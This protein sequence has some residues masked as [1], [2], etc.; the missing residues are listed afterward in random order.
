MLRNVDAI[1]ARAVQ[2]PRGHAFLQL[3]YTVLLAAYMGVFVYTGSTEGGASAFG[4]TTMAL[5]LPVIIVSSGLVN[6]ANERFTRRL[7]NTARHWISL[8]FFFAILAVLLVW[9]T[10]GGGYPWWIS[11]VSV[12]LTLVIF[13]VRPL[14][15]VLRAPAVSAHDA[16][17]RPQHLPAP[18]RVTTILLGVYLALACAVVLVPVGSWLVTVVGMIAVIVAASA[19]RAS[20]GLLGTG[21]EWRL[22]QWTAFGVSALV[23]FLL[24]V[25]I[26]A[27]DFVTPIVTVGA[28]VLVAASLI[29]SAFIPGRSRGASQA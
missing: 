10:V 28:G 2:M 8:G 6:G 5:V 4:G 16:P 23:M 9:G 1:R 12:A 17:Q 29:G 26:I 7:R 20:W 15:V 27:T 22:P 18:V 11:L 14:G 19:Q 3:A 24:P 25:L 13:G 21:Y